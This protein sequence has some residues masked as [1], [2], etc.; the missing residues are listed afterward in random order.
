MGLAGDENRIIRFGSRQ[1]TAHSPVQL[2]RCHGG[3]DV[4]GCPTSPKMHPFVRLHHQLSGEPM[5]HLFDPLVLR[6]LRLANRIAV[7]P[8]CQYS[9]LD[10]VANDWHLVNLGGFARGGAG[11]VISEATA[12]CPEGRISP[13]DLGIWS[14]AQIEP[15]LRITRFIQSQ[16]AVAGIQLAHAG[17][18]ASC[19]RPWSGS[20]AVPLGQGGWQTVAPSAIAFTDHYPAPREMSADEVAAIPNA[21]AQAATRAWQAGFQVA[22]IHAAHGYLL[23]QFL[24][25]LSNQRTD[26]YGGAFANRIR[27]LLETTQAVR[28]VWPAG[29]PLLVRVSATDWVEGGW[30]LE[31]TVQLAAQL[32]TLGVDL[33]DVSSGGTAMNAVIPVG[34]AYQVPF[35][36]EVRQRTGLATGAVG[37]ITTATQAQSVIEAEQADLVLLGRELLRDPHWPLRAAETLAVPAQW[38]PQ[39]LRAAPAGSVERR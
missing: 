13:Q 37:L 35:A 15:L 39:Y 23:H 22:E 31:E 33:L 17:R 26:A 14:D 5:P 7:S 2:G 24:S 34:P 30:T 19:Y 1:C 36:A 6:D 25:P 27:L 9:A 28:A 10:G 29:L 3:C 21:F 20:G 8:M 38:P 18:K 4:T 32:K 11:L 16:G 12:I